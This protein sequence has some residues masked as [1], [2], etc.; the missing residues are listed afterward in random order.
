MHVPILLL[1]HL[2]QFLPLILPCQVADAA[3]SDAAVAA[4]AAAVAAVAPDPAD[5]ATA[6]TA[7]AAAAAAA[8][9]AVVV[10]SDAA[11]AAA[12]AAC[13][14]LKHP[15]GCWH[16]PALKRGTRDLRRWPARIG[17]S[18]QPSAADPADCHGSRG[19]RLLGLRLQLD[20][21]RRHYQ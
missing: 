3:A 1:G 16:S 4:A 6:A 8:A 2:L 11:A 17:L 10:A 18:W 21:R 5:D 12:A 9:A 15:I 19:H 13:E 20:C 7:E 14:Q